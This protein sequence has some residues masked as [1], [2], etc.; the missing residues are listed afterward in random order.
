MTPPSLSELA[1]AAANAVNAARAAQRE[2]EPLKLPIYAPLPGEQWTNTHS[3]LPAIR[4]WSHPFG[5]KADSLRQL[6]ELANAKGGYYP[7]GRNGYWHAGLHFDAGTAGI[8]DQS[9]VRCLADGEVVAYRIDSQSPTSEFTVNREPVQRPFTRN[10]VLVRHRL[11][12]PKIAGSDDAPPSLTFYSLYMHLQDWSAYQADPSLKRPAFWPPGK[13]L[14]VKESVQDTVQGLEGHTWQRTRIGPHGGT[15]LSGLARGSEVSVSDTGSYRKLQNIPGPLQLMQGGELQGYVSFD[16]LEPGEAGEYRTTSNLK[17]RPAA[18]GVGQE[19]MTLPKGTVVRISGEGTYRKLEWVNQ[20][21]HF[22]SLLSEPEPQERDCCV[23]PDEPMP[24]KAG[25]LI[26]HLG[27]YHFCYD[28]E[29]TQQLHLEVFSGQ[30]VGG[31]IHFCREWAQRLPA[32]GKTWLQVPKGTPIA[33]DRVDLSAERYPIVD[34]DTPRSAAELYLPKSL[35]DGLKPEHKLAIP[36]KDGRKACTWYRLENLLHDEQKG[37]RRWR[38]LD[39]IVWALNETQ[40]DDVATLGTG[41][42]RLR[43]LASSL[44]W[45]APLYVWQVCASGWEQTGRKAQPVGCL[46]PSR[47]TVADVEAKLRELLDPLRQRGMG[48]L[49]EEESHDFLV[50]LGFQ[51]DGGGIAKWREA[52]QPFLSDSYRRLP[53]RGLLFGLPQKSP[54]GVLKNAWWPDAAWQGVLDDRE[55]RGRRL[56][57]SAPRAAYCLVLGLTVLWALGLL[58]SFAN[59]RSQIA[60]AQTALGVLRQPGDLDSQIT[61]LHELTRELGRLDYQAQ[62]GVPWFLRFGLNHNAELQA[63]LWPFYAEANNRLLRDSAK[64]HLERQLTDLAALP[65]GSPERAAR[66][67]EGHDQLKAYLMLA[68]PEKVD[69]AF[70]TKALHSLE[71]DRPGIKP[72]LWQGLSPSLWAFY[73]EHLQ[74]HP[75]WRIQAD[76]KVVAQARQVLLGQLGQRNGVASLYEKMLEGAGNNYPD[77][78][79]L[80]MVGET[81]SSRLFDT[82]TSVPG[83]FTRQAWEG[84]VRAAIDEIAE[85]RREEI[86]WVLS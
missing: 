14:R 56:G 73:A 80:Q 59:N 13:L 36:A 19:L 70:L 69:A 31:F 42:I 46:L 1:A 35:L 8:L 37:L 62:Q 64:A 25:A 23:V 20:Y 54:D 78:H 29:P 17:V 47:A 52:L 3:D 77:L 7:L 30:D 76:S 5:S 26:G 12:A 50:R 16:Y 86:D 74:S 11:Q 45:Q 81:D 67:V 43:E 41:V 66:A 79:L 61:A 85:A 83:A 55:S 2:G 72:G 32:S 34:T 22:D 60:D 39:G 40:R 57:W 84:H 6:T 28:D 75:D 71:A 10:F 58:L 68:R 82:A 49:V 21:V 63:A 44:R 4:Q 38:P 51:L 24:I 15:V 53:L 18:S 65:P 9:F 48:Q 33:P 27:T